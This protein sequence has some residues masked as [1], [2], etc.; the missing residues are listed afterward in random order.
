MYQGKEVC[1]GC[2]K[3]GSE[4][5]R[6]EKNDLCGSCRENLNYGIEKKKDDD[7]TVYKTVD[8][9]W[10]KLRFYND[11]DVGRG[12]EDAFVSLL[13]SID[14]PTM[15]S[16]GWVE[17][18]SHDAA[19]GGGASHHFKITEQQADSIKA[20]CCILTKQQDDYLKKMKD[21]EKEREAALSKVVR[22]E[23]NRIFNE[24]IEKGR[25]LLFQ[26]NEGQITMEDFN[27]KINRY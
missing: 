15:K 18:F 19:N 12:L 22:D 4:Q 24:G 14:R 6:H 25:D 27:S 17:L 3:P 21:I 2:G 7:P 1:Q 8:A 23:R 5:W 11:G 26:M 20:V 10:Y 9:K 13:K 16:T